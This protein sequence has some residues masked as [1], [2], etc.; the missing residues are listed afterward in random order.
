MHVL[1]L[2]EVMVIRL[3]E[4]YQSKR[5]HYTCIYLKGKRKQDILQAYIWFVLVYSFASPIF[6]Y[7]LFYDYY[8]RPG[9]IMELWYKYLVCTVIVGTVYCL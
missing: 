2:Y 7:H 6:F 1:R 5:R 3:L 9:V 4:E 8:L